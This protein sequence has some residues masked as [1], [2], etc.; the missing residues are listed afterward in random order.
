MK[1][2][3]T[4]TQW[5]AAANAF[6]TKEWPKYGQANP[7]PESTRDMVIAMCHDGIELGIRKS[8]ISKSLG[9]TQATLWN[10]RQRA[11]AEAIS[12][13]ARQSIGLVLELPDGSKIHGLTLDDIEKLLKR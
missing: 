7:A 11:K 1:S 10:W 12:K 6:K 13:M 8:E 9:I 2:K 3:Q 4:L 5:K